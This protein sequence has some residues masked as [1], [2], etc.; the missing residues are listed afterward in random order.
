MT[1]RGLHSPNS[2]EKTFSQFLSHLLNYIYFL[3]FLVDF[4]TIFPF[5]GRQSTGMR[6]NVVRPNTDT[7]L[8]KQKYIWKGIYKSFYKQKTSLFINF[9]HLKNKPS[10]SLAKHNIH[11]NYTLKLLTP[12]PGRI[13]CSYTQILTTGLIPLAATLLIL[14]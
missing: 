3:W 11:A 12:H 1:V 10:V 2:I 6:Q 14:P 7:N 9:F 4:Q 8:T 5:F 13:Y